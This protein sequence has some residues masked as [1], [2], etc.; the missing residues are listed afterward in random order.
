MRLQMI[1]SRDTMY[2]KLF[3]FHNAFYTGNL[4]LRF[5][6]ANIYLE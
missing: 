3:I 6:F 1:L 4:L 2:G 5:S